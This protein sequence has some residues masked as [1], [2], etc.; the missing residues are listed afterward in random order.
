VTG[1]AAAGP[2]AAGPAAGLQA[3]RTALAWS[4]TSLAL[5]GNGALVLVRHLQLDLHPAGLGVA[6][7]GFVLAAVTAVLGRRRS[8][9]LL[10]APGAPAALP[11][12]V[13]V[14][15]GVAIAV[16]CAAT[17]LTLL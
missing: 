15:L 8:R 4:R 10:A 11:A 13:I 5:L 12:G 17:T 14:G 2:A 7:A 1:P 16:L 3:E 9:A 6:V